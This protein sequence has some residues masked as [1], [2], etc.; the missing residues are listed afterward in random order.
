M[1]IGLSRWL[2]RRIEARR[3]I[4][5]HGVGD[6]AFPVQR[7][8]ELMLWIRANFVVR[9]LAEMIDDV[10]HRRQSRRRGD[11]AITF[12]DGLRNQFVHAYPILHKLGLS[13]TVFVCPGLIEQRR[14]L[15]NH[16]AR[17]RLRRIPA[18][19]RE[20]LARH[21]GAPVSELEPLVEWMKTLALAPRRQV[22]TMLHELTPDFVP[23]E[24]ERL[25]CDVLSWEELDAFDPR[26]MAVGSH[27]MDHPILPTLSDEEIC[28][29]LQ[30]SRAILE[31]RLG[32]TV[33][34]FCYPNGAVDARV[35]KLTARFYRAALS[36]I[37]GVV[38]AA[39][40]PWTIR[41]IPASPDLHLLA[42]RLHRPTA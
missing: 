4:T 20:Q 2:A 12:D 1:N 24:A 3:I 33:D 35:R 17:A 10:V 16:E 25:S 18:H 8:E 37:D 5:L 7:F 36:S 23:T 26:I 32:R 39:T 11:I 38:D 41:R 14:W 27:T 6:A 15:W 22:E 29:E 13:A 9:P 34:L 31:Q 21:L 28:H 42:W 30:L 19:R 40:D